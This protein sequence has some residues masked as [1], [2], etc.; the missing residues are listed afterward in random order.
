[1]SLFVVKGGYLWDFSVLFS[2]LDQVVLVLVTCCPIL[3]VSNS[4]FEKH[5][6]GLV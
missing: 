4:G 6:E 1:M 3:R 5:A 2:F